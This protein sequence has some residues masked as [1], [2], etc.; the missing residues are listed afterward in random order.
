MQLRTDRDSVESFPEFL[1][2]GLV[3]SLSISSVQTSVLRSLLP[4]GHLV[5]VVLLVG[6]RCSDGGGGGHRCCR[7]PR[8]PCCGSC[9]CDVVLMKISCL[10]LGREV[11]SKGIS[12]SLLLPS[13]S[14]AFGSDASLLLLLAF[15]PDPG[16][17]TKQ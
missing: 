13:G 14:D 2:L 5:H 8:Q 11:G 6:G 3:T 1:G 4:S 16:P 15:A 9:C 12:L 7:S 17:M 10:S